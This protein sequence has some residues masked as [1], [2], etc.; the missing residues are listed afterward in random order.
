[1]ND[2]AHLSALVAWLGFGLAV[3]FGVIANRVHFCT[4]GAV[5]DVVNIGDWGRM[6]MWMLAIAVAILGANLLSLLGYVDL[7]RSIYLTQRFPW[8]S[9]LVGG[10]LFGVG[11]T[12]ASGCGSRNLM[13]LGAGSL[14]AAV[15]LTF[16]ALSAYMTMKGVLALPRAALLDAH[17]IHVESGQSLPSVLGRIAGRAGPG[18]HWAVMLAVVAGLLAFVFMD[19]RFRA[20]REQILGG[21]AI[22]AIIAAGWYVTGY[23]GHLAED[24]QTLE[25]AWVGTNTHRPESF[26]YV[27]PM[28]YAL[29][30][31][32]LWTD[33]SLKI[34]FGIAIVAGL[35]L[36]SLG[37]A[38]ATRSFRIETF[39][40][41]SDL[42]N[43]VV[44][45]VLMG[46]GGVTA[47]GCSI[48]Q[49]L[50]GVST[51]ALGSFLA[52]LAIIAGC[53]LTMKVLY[54]RMA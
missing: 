10:F 1:M 46:F 52:L 29:E 23:F 53:A 37:Y 16:L 45:A 44:G 50:T 21:A 49:G 43:H 48:G 40:S 13:R 34:T 9:N 31:L 22:G 14:K 20:S 15:V 41:A 32:L 35:L 5:S 24:P 19:V 11:M 33:A 54:W 4:M 27:G 28:A 47:L 51:L 8:L 30:L 3:A 38:L 7:N 6:R 36:G 18:L 2:T 12:L 26:S 39:A 17:A 25:E 42:R